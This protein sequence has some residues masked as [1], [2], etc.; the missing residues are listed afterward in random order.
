MAVRA[1][2]LQACTD[3]ERIADQVGVIGADHHL[4]GVHRDSQRKLDPVNCCQLAGEVD[5]SLLEFDSGIDG[6]FGV[7]GPDFGYAPDRHETVA[8]VLGHPGAMAF[9]DR[10]QQLVVLPDDLSSRLRIDQFLERGRAGQV[11]EQDGHGLPDRRRNDLGAW[12]IERRAAGPAEPGGRTRR[13]PAGPARA[14]QRASAALTEPGVRF[15][16]ATARGAGGTAHLN[17]A[18]APVRR[19]PRWPVRRN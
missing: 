12:I 7:T 9:G 1:F 17:R 18:L 10:A 19:D 4:T 11:G 6:V 15:V 8:D 13:R 16:G 3:V 2:G 14:L 5:E